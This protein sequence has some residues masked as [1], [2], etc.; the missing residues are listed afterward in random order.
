MSI[1]EVIRKRRRKLDLTLKDI[2]NKVG[3]SEATAQRWESG[4]ITNIRFGRLEKLASALQLSIHVH[5]MSIDIK[6]KPPT[7]TA[8]SLS[9]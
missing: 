4:V 2:A 3:V 8:G 7:I 1:A 9:S 6:N 5:F